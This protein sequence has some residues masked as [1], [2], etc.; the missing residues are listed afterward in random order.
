MTLRTLNYGN[1]GIFLIMGNAG[2]CPSTV[3]LVCAFCGQRS[4]AGAR[5]QNMAPTRDKAGVHNDA[6]NI[7]G[8]RL[9]AS[10][11]FLAS[12]PPVSCSILVVAVALVVILGRGGRSECG[13]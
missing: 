11:T 8:K 3:V 1:Y 4:W 7:T 13:Q 9:R 12:A 5:V 2:F 10:V 6:C